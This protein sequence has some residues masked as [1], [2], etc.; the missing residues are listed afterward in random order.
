[1]P[2]TVTALLQVRTYPVRRLT[3]QQPSDVATDLADPRT[4]TRLTAVRT[5]ADIATLDLSTAVRKPNMDA[6]VGSAD[7]NWSVITRDDR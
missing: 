1:M 7:A 2:T 4:H 5:R 3:C 6:A